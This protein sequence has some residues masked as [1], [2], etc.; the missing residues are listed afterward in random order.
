MPGS[1]AYSLAYTLRNPLARMLPLQREQMQVYRLGEKHPPAGSMLDH[2]P[3][4]ETVPFVLGP[5]KTSQAR[6]NLQ[7]NFT[8]LAIMTTASSVAAGGFRAQFY[9]KKKDLRF[10]DRGVQ[11]ANI[12][13]SMGGGGF[14]GAFFLR[15]P[16]VFDLP[17]SQI[18]VVVQNLESVNNTIEVAFYGQ[19]LRFN[20]PHPGANE[21]PGGPVSSWPFTGGTGQ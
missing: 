15:E 11:K 20:Q 17:D 14:G 6:V 4:W 5:L 21:F 1:K 2:A 12:A 7:R 16:Y 9:D 3:M 8:L 10:A 18:L 13:G 19:V